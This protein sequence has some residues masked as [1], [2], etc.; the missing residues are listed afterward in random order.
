MPPPG[1]AGAASAREGL[2]YPAALRKAPGFV[3]FGHYELG[4]TVECVTGK[5][6]SVFVS[7][8]VF[9]AFGYQ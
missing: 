2:L 5:R 3:A 7:E 8:G 9:E 6:I 1:C 4:V